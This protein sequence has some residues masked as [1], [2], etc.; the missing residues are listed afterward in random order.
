MLSDGV[1]VTTANIVVFQVMQELWEMDGGDAGLKL[2]KWH[3][4]LM[5]G[6]GGDAGASSFKPI[7]AER[8]SV[9]VHHA[10]EQQ[11]EDIARKSKKKKSKTVRHKSYDEADQIAPPAKQDKN[12]TSSLSSKHVEKEAIVGGKKKE[13]AD[14]AEKEELLRCLDVIEADQGAILGKQSKSSSSSSDD[15]N[16]DSTTASATFSSSKANRNPDK[17][18]TTKKKTRSKRKESNAKTENDYFVEVI[19]DELKRENAEL[20]FGLVAREEQLKKAAE[21]IKE[22]V[23][24]NAR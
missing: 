15:D 21:K 10:D 20:R 9:L 19:I 23:E 11:G 6:E 12:L 18:A 17:R 3:E 5:Q 2:K 8:T 16:R 24:D 14:K 1:R 13:R 7:R 22:L 4:I